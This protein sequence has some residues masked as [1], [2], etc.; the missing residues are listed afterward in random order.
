MRHALGLGDRRQ[1]GQRPVLPAGRIRFSTDDERSLGY[2][3]LIA[4]A[5]E[6]FAQRDA[7]TTIFSI[8]VLVKLEGDDLVEC[9]AL[10]SEC[11]ASLRASPANWRLYLGDEVSTQYGF[12]AR[13]SSG[14][15]RSMDAR[16]QETGRTI[17]QMHPLIF[18]TRALSIVNRLRKL[19]HTAR[20][21]GGSV[22]YGNGV[23]A[24]AV[25]GTELPP[26]VVEYS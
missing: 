25:L 19:I 11:E 14:G 18:R 8:N 21:A 13:H 10:L 12:V 22:L 23:C 1:P 20:D 9:S 26:G 24:R 7:E 17:R 16:S 6:H 5:F 4:P 2:F 3:T 15:S